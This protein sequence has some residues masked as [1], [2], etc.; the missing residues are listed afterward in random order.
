MVTLILFAIILGVL[1][2]VHELGHFVVARRNGIKADEFGFGFP[3]R[4]IGLTKHPKSGKWKLV[5]GNKHIESKNT[6]YSINLI[7]LG[8]FVKIKGENG[9]GAN[10]PDSFASK[11]AWV[12]IK[13]L[14]AGVTMN[15]I[16]A[17]VVLSAVFMIGTPREVE[18]GTAGSRVQIASI[19]KDSPAFRMGVQ[20]GDVV[21]E[22]CGG[23]NF[24]SCVKITGVSQFQKIIGD[25]KGQEILMRVERG[26][27]IF[28]LKG[29]PRTNPPEGQGPL[30]VS[31]VQTA[32]IPL[33]WH[34][35]IIEGAKSIYNFFLLVI[36]VIKGL[37]LGTSS[38]VELSGPVKIFQYTGQMAKLG[39]VYIL[40]L[41]AIL[42][43]NLG[44]INAL[45]I[46]ALDGGRIFFIIIEKIKR[47]PIN[48][49]FENAA[50]TAGFFLLILLMIV[51]TFNDLGIGEKIKGLF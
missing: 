34:K 16:L 20:E 37:I 38:G 42:S 28:E 22:I 44:I 19:A 21:K 18:E 17:W 26:K 33:P 24:Q 40:Q 7:P 27:D 14:A 13:V 50:N 4:I 10:E 29:I 12:R 39:T 51:V 32:V 8:G 49:K 46:P 23:N 43:V 11:S 48:P 45:P 5:F 2:F 6:V 30:G 47:S 9:Q 31:P 41:L 35:A 15:F 25:H 36:F 1:I 3:P